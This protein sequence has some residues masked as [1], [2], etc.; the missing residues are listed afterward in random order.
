M[1]PFLA[2]TIDKR[3]AHKHLPQNVFVQDLRRAVPGVLAKSVVE[4]LILPS[5]PEEDR[6]F[7][8]DYYQPWTTPSGEPAYTLFNIPHQL[9]AHHFGTEVGIDSFTAQEKR[10]LLRYYTPVPG[11]EMYF[12]K[13]PVTEME[14]VVLAD[15]LDP[16]GLSLTEE[17]RMRLA[18]LLEGVPD[19]VREDIFHGALNV[20][21]THPYFFEH[22]NEHVPGMMVIEAG[23]QFCMAC[24]HRFGQT[25]FQ[26]VQFI[27]QSF[28]TR[29][30]DYLELAYPAFLKCELVQVD[31]GTQGEWNAVL[32]RVTVFQRGE[33]CAEMEVQAQ[34]ISKRSF[35]RLRAGRLK[36]DPLHRFLPIETIH[37]KVSLWDPV[38]SRYHRVKLWDISMEGLRVEFI[39]PV[40]EG[41]APPSWEVVLYFEEVGFIRSRCLLAWQRKEKELH[42]AGF[43]FQ[44]MSQEDKSLLQMA[45]RQYCH[46]R[47]E[48]EQL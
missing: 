25:P 45:I 30:V 18:N 17:E 9:P 3:L 36:T 35:Q 33:L 41:T 7:F 29:F 22:P 40:D 4:N 24:W 6:R 10:T 5:L 15:I 39:D 38:K 14:D 12:L 27:L 44:E 43:R 1:K 47:R 26:G 13:G 21:P 42:W 19:L 2:G 16:K 11:S 46:V 48:R 31:R 28:N 34:V 32:F 20:D 23:R 8:L 37:H